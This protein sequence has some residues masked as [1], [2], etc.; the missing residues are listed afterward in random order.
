[1]KTKDETW[2]PN[3]RERRP[4]TL[5]VSARGGEVRTWG[6]ATI[7]RPELLIRDCPP[8]L[9]E[10]AK[11][12]LW[13]LAGWVVSTNHRLEPGEELC[14]GEGRVRLEAADEGLEL[15]ELDAECGAF[16]PGLGGVLAQRAVRAAGSRG[17]PQEH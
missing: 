9:V 2:H 6:L 10:E 5:C 7:N 14:C 4:G 16:V 13:D 15:W 17:E 1:M 11:A 8:A 12:L 3:P